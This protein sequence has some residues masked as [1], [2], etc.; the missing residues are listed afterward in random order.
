MRSL[1]LALLP[2]ACAALL[3]AS[4]AAVAAEPLTAP[5]HGGVLT[6][7]DGR[8][9]ESLVDREGLHVWFHTD[10][11]AP[12]MAGR[13]GGTAT[14]RL[15]GGGTREVTLALR[16][17]AA[18]GA[19][20]YFCPMHAEVVQKSPGKCEPCGGMVLFHQDELFG[21][22]DL[23]GTDPRE[24]TA[25]VRLTGL[26]GARKEASFSPAFPAPV[27]KAGQQEAGK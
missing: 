11:K 16:A 5:L 12:A 23:A 22:A 3:A 9:F 6:E 20:V 18:G 24:V 14:L 19:G 21:A 8:V 13:A 7:Q 25:Q 17:P 26:K 4:T 1:R 10:E 2:A 15:P 27:G